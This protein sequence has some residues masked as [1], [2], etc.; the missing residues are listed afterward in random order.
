MV[1]LPPIHRAYEYVLWLQRGKTPLTLI[2]A[3][4]ACCIPGLT[5]FTKTLIIFAPVSPSRFA[6]FFF[7]FVIKLFHVELLMWSTISAL[8]TVNFKMPAMSPPGSS[9]LYRRAMSCKENSICGRRDRRSFLLLPCPA[10]GE[11]AFERANLLG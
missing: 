3:S 8:C 2:R 5:H 1:L 4:E 7:I 10:F 6:P 11:P 9:S